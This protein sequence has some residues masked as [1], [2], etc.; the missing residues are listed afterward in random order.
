MVF[1]VTIA[2]FP[3]RLLLSG[4]SL[5]PQSGLPF[6]GSALDTIAI[7]KQIGMGIEKTFGQQ[8]PEHK[9]ANRIDPHVPK[10]TL[11]IPMR[12][13]AQR[14]SFLFDRLRRWPMISK[15]EII[16]VDDKSG[17]R[18]HRYVR[19]FIEEMATPTIRMLSLDRH[20][21][22]GAAVR[23]G[24]LSA[25]GKAVVFTDADLPMGLTPVEELFGIL[26]A[27]A[28]VVVGERDHPDTSLS[29]TP[30]FRQ[31]MSRVFRL[32]VSAVTDIKPVTDSQCGLKGFRRKAAIDL[33]TDLKFQGFAFDIEILT[34][35]VAGKMKIARLPVT[36][37]PREKSSWNFLKAAI[38]LFFAAPV[39]GRRSR[40]IR[41]NR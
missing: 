12:N 6:N 20:R 21:G 13:E 18:T 35:A 34:H 28:D 32:W 15:T 30:W 31:I 40:R 26:D 5:A 33:F 41:E 8:T 14:L 7:G 38:Y 24:V 4:K 27:G 39:A 25:R 22:K 36:C 2:G 23:K 10:H 11:V 37:Q 1:I 9:T 29:Q 17:D 16:F 19:A 3:G